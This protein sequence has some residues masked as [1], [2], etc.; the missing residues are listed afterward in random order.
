MDQN[1]TH[2]FLGIR[3]ILRITVF[4]VLFLFTLSLAAHLENNNKQRRVYRE[5]HD[6]NV[7]NINN[8][9]NANLFR[10]AR[11]VYHPVRNHVNQPLTHLSNHEH[12]R[13]RKHQNL[14]NIPSPHG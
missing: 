10:I 9:D 5:A 12:P 14:L 6:N 8:D 3:M 2:Y 13:H 7:N 11:E 1:Q 4:L